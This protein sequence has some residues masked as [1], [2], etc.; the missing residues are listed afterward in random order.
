[1]LEPEPAPDYATRAEVAEAVGAYLK[2]LM[3]Q[4]HTLSD[5]IEAMGKEVKELKK[6]EDERMKELVKVTPA[7]SLYDRIGSVIGSP[8]AVVHGNSSLAKAGPA[9]A[10]A[11]GKD[12]PTMVP[13]LNEMILANMNRGG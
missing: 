8:E 7:A 9:E 1:M 12:G 4:M 13:W 5:Q 11:T 10:P 3:E 6:S 2:P